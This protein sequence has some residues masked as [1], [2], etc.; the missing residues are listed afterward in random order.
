MKHADKLFTAFQRLHS[1]QEFSGTGIGL[2]IVSRI[3]ARHGGEV[4]AEGEPGKGA[5]FY[6]TLQ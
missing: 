4:W 6:F 2:S 1:E 3:I 5:C